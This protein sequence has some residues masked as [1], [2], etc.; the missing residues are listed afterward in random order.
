MTGAASDGAAAVDRAVD[1]SLIDVLVDPIAG[2]ATTDADRVDD[3]VEHL[4]VGPVGGGGDRV[5]DAVHDDLFVQIIE[6]VLVDEEPMPSTEHR[7]ALSET[8][9]RRGLRAIDA[10]AHRQADDEPEGHETNG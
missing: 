4:L 10:L 1:E 5:G 8:F 9:Q 2:L 6:V 3:A 7:V